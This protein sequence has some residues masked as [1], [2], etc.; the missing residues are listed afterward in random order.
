MEGSRWPQFL[1]MM[2]LSKRINGLKET[3]VPEHGELSCLSKIPEWTLFEERFV[4]FD[5]FQHFRRKHKEPTIDPSS[6][7]SLAFPRIP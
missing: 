2:E 3:Q 6:I 1:E 4:T 7:A 5:F